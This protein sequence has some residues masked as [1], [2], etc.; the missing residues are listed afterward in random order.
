MNDEL[1]E[2]IREYARGSLSAQE[3]AE[4]ESLALEDSEVEEA[5]E[6]ELAPVG[7]AF[8]EA[9]PPPE[10]P[11]TAIQS[12]MTA[13]AGSKPRT[14]GFLRFVLAGA[15]AAIALW[16]LIPRPIRVTLE[17]TDGAVFANGAALSPGASLPFGEEIVCINPA[18][19][20]LGGIAAPTGPGLTV[21]TVDKVGDRIVFRPKVGD[22]AFSG[23]SDR[24]RY[25]VVSSGVEARPLGTRF[26]VTANGGSE[27]VVSVYAS[28]VEVTNQ[29]SARV[30]GEG[31][32][33]EGGA[34]QHIKDDPV[35]KLM[36]A[37]PVPSARGLLVLPRL[38][39]PPPDEALLEKVA[40][41]TRIQN[42]AERY[43][44]L[45]VALANFQERASAASAARLA[46]SADGNLASL[47]DAELLALARSQI[48]QSGDPEVA[49]RIISVIE[50]RPSAKRSL[51]TD[52]FDRLRKLARSFG[53]DW[54][55]AVEAARELEGF[56]KNDDQLAIAETYVYGGIALANDR[57]ILLD[58]ER[59]LRKILISDRAVR[60]KR[61][62]AIAC[63]RLGEALYHATR[64]QESLQ[65]TLRAVQDWPVPRWTVH[66]ATRLAETNARSREECFRLLSNGLRRDP[67]AYTYERALTA[68]HMYVRDDRDR[69]VEYKLGKWIAETFSNIPMKQLEMAAW[70]GIT[71]RD[72]ETMERLFERGV[73]LIGGI[74][75][76]PE[77]IRV[78]VAACRYMRG[79][80]QSAYE[81]IGI[82]GPAT[83]ASA[84]YT[85]YCGIGNYVE[86]LRHH[87]QIPSESRSDSYGFDRARLLCRLGRKDEALSIL[88][89]F[90]ERETVRLEKDGWSS[91][92]H[93]LVQ[94][95]LLVGEIT[96]NPSERAAAIHETD[97]LL[98]LGPR[99]SFDFE[100]QWLVWLARLRLLQN[101]FVAVQKILDEL[102]ARSLVPTVEVQADEVRQRLRAAVGSGA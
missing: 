28:R 66:A 99:S 34:V 65:W 100:A 29:S 71:F 50:S 77:G 21:F 26:S 13:R 64:K 41:A 7:R 88:Q 49:G 96:S 86:A 54:E 62:R 4:L 98:K 51:G 39:L 40:E 35:A 84:K 11:E 12:V 89:R 101:D 87:E 17:S 31:H 43:A 55:K 97:R 30:I 23:H 81:L 8:R 1:R 69:E 85:F 46:M 15:A 5:I 93:D 33:L 73:R 42:P 91:E 70:F 56:Q 72:Y 2:R 94:S 53:S 67:S 38:P 79:D 9:F 18:R 3:A 57:Q 82:N 48:A 76:V 74:E 20:G 36:D 24:V 92:T 32:A 80:V 37:V 45:A 27:T 10:L 68:V 95:L 52:Y 14:S 16:F 59:R 61:Y 75:N 44:R 60:D 47:T 102:D 25:Q 63:H 22:F 78:N 19:F 90:A 6:A 58:A 83:S